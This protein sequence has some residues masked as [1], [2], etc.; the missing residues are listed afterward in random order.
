MPLFSLLSFF[1]SYEMEYIFKCLCVISC[2]RNGDK[3]EKVLGKMNA[4]VQLGKIAADTGKEADRIYIMHDTFILPYLLH[5]GTVPFLLR[6]GSPAKRNCKN[7][8]GSL[9]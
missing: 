9:A 6:W 1:V 8:V 2:S 4:P 7:F 3:D 5:R